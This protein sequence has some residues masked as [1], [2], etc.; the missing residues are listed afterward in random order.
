MCRLVA[1][2]RQ[3]FDLKTVLNTCVVGVEDSIPLISYQAVPFPQLKGDG[4]TRYLYDL[5]HVLFDDYDDEYT[6]GLTR[7]QR[8]KY[9]S[10]I[11]RDRF[12]RWIEQEVTKKYMANVQELE[13]SD[14][15][16]AAILHLTAHKV[17]K[18]CD[19]LLAEGN[20]RLCLLVARLDSAD[21]HFMDDIKQ[22]LDAWREQNVLS[23]ITEEIRT[24]YEI[25]AG[26]VT[27]SKGKSGANVPPE[28]KA[29]TFS[30]SEKHN[31]SWLQCF[32][33]GLFYGRGEKNNADSISRIE[34][35]VREYQGRLDRSEETAQPEDDPV[36][37]MLRLYASQ[38][39][40]TKK[41]VQIPSIPAELS[42]LS[43][44]FDRGVLFTFANALTS[45]IAALKLDVEATDLLVLSLAHDLAAAH[46]IAGSAFVLLHLSNPVSRKEHVL[47]L[48]HT[49]AAHLTA[50]E[51]GPSGSDSALWKTLTTHLR[52]PATWLYGVKASFAASS[53]GG[54]NSASE[55]RYLIRAEQW[56]QAH[57]CFVKR[58]APAF[59]ID[60]DW[61]SLIDACRLFGD[62]P[63]Q[64]VSNWSIHGGL[65]ND[66]ARLM[67]NAI[68]RQDSVKVA[69]IRN[70]LVKLGKSGRDHSTIT[71]IKLG[72]L[73]RHELEEH[74]AIKEMANTLARMSVEGGKVGTTEELLEMPVTSDVRL[75]L[76]NGMLGPTTMSTTGKQN[77]ASGVQADADA[78]IDMD[79]DADVD[80]RDI[81]RKTTATK[82]TTAERARRTGTA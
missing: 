9:A 49:F 8:K 24:V 1:D 81:N 32:S 46:D 48:L 68:A 76:E 18:A 25:C 27:I 34:D 29:S 67:T 47:S 39:P 13:K 69:T 26:N 59:V 45:N 3:L 66:F 36:W 19:L 62:D 64:H 71:T 10:R 5:A 2:C 7:P 54:Q 38:Q 42:G 41:T 43:T 58:V 61:L 56:L 65:Y 51:E 17:G 70:R 44:V 35:A 30:I 22:Q 40:D 77:K 75:R 14:R 6:L 28:D 37:T 23:E 50:P 11:K 72:Q 21:Q 63:S 16:T 52:L 4:S 15:T 12:A 82:N 80:M 78:D 31:L 57:D 53:A 20:H 73:S 74:V 55:L 33:L 79:V 60:E